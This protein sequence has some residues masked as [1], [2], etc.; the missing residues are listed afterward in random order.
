MFNF[1]K[2]FGNKKS[3]KME[4]TQQRKQQIQYNLLGKIVPHHGH[5]VFEIEL[6][7]ENPTVDDVKEAEYKKR[8]YTMAAYPLNKGDSALRRFI[9]K[10]PKDLITKKGFVYIPALNKQN[11]LKKYKKT[12]QQAEY[13]V[14]NPAM[15]IND[16]YMTKSF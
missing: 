1:E 2:I 6:G 9:P 13:Y 15:D 5:T 7:L 12:Q 3:D 11:A 8:D 10:E 16:F 4:V 14:K